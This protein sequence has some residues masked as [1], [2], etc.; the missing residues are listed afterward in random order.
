MRS[1]H[2]PKALSMLTTI[3]D[4]HQIEKLTRKEMELQTATKQLRET[5]QRLQELRAELLHVTDARN[6]LQRQ[7]Q[8]LLA[9]R[10]D[11][12]AL[13]S[14]VLALRARLVHTGSLPPSN[15]NENDS[16]NTHTRTTTTQA[17][18]PSHAD[19][20][21]AK[22]PPSPGPSIMSRMTQSPARASSPVDREVVDM[23]SEAIRCA[24]GSATPKWY[25][26]LRS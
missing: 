14:T 4:R 18:L 20:G 12:D 10:Q 17:P 7:L 1:N 25:A 23:V 26:K 9:R 8:Q 11:I 13:K 15:E 24:E 19:S 22:A 5:E 21:Y 6:S 3:C 2:Y 16:G